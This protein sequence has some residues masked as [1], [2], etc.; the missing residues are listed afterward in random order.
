MSMSEKTDYYDNHDFLTIAPRKID[1]RGGIKNRVVP[2]FCAVVFWQVCHAQYELD[3]WKSKVCV[4]EEREEKFG[5]GGKFRDGGQE[6]CPC[7][8]VIAC[9]IRAK[10]VPASCYDCLSPIC[11]P[12]VP[13]LANSPPN[14]EERHCD[15][16]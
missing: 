6:R 1:G 15:C 9:T 4:H 8:Q 12:A 10:R 3:R 5:R 11:Q 7:C 13:A 2:E 14:L 16:P